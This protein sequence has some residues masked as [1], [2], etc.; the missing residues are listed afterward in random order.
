MAPRLKSVYKSQLRAHFR[1]C[2]YF[3]YRPVPSFTTYIVFLAR[4]LAASSIPCYLNVVRILH[5]Q[6][7]FPN[8]PQELPFK[9]PKDLLTRGIKPPHGDIVHQ[10]LPITPDILHKLHGKLDLPVSSPSSHFFGSL[11]YLSRPRARLILTNTCA[12]GILKFHDIYLIQLGL[13]MY[14][15]Q[16]H[17]LPLKFHCKFTLQSQIHSYNTRNSCKF[18]LPFCRTRTKQFSVFYQGPK[19]YNTLNTNIIN[20]SSPFSFKRALKAFICNNY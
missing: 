16:N 5:P 14:S 4:T 7:G 11:I 1:F 17:T 13:F 20:A 8:N 12:C 6:C 9:F 15:Y 3:G 10:K 18:R 2:L 19:F